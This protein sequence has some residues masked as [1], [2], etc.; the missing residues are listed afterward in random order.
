MGG[1]RV[2]GGCAVV[3]LGCGSI[4]LLMGM[5]PCTVRARSRLLAVGLVPCLW[6]EE[7]VVEV[8]VEW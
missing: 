3:L 5:L 7:V 1:S 4:N 8:E 6:L 2:R